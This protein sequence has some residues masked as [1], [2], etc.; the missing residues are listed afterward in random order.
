MTGQHE[1]SMKTRGEIRCS[2]MV[3]ISCSACGTRHDV[4]YVVSMN[5]TSS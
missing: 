4:P 3:S 2:E 1:T 5:E